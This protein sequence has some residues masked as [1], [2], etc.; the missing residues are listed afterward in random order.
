MK[1]IFGFVKHFRTGPSRLRP[2]LT[3]PLIMTNYNTAAK[4]DGVVKDLCVHFTE[5][6]KLENLEKNP[7]STGGTKYNSTYTEL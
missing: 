1:N 7:Q 4:A 2:Y 3:A 5:G 6:V